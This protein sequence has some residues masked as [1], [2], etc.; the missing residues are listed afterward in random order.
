MTEKFITTPQFCI[1]SLFFV[2]FCFFLFLIVIW[3]TG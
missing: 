2:F 1:I 3:V